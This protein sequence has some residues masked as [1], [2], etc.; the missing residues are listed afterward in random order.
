MQSPTPA[1]TRELLAGIR[2]YG[3]DLEPDPAWDGRIIPPHWLV[4]LP[5]TDADRAARVDIETKQAQIDAALERVPA[6]LASPPD[7]IRQAMYDAK[8]N[9]E[10]I[11][12]LLKFGS[13]EYIGVVAAYEILFRALEAQAPKEGEGQEKAASRE[14]G[15]DLE[16]S[17]SPR[18]ASRLAPEGW[19]ILGNDETLQGGDKYGYWDA[20]NLQLQEV[21][22][23]A[24]DP[25]YRHQNGTQFY[26]I[27]RLE[28]SRTPG[29]ASEPAPSPS[30]PPE[31][32]K[33]DTL[34]AERVSV[35]IEVRSIVNDFHRMDTK[36]WEELHEVNQALW[37]HRADRIL[38]A[39]AVSRSPA[40][41]LDIL[42]TDA[43][44]PGTVAMF[45][46]GK[47]VGMIKNI[48]EGSDKTQE[49]DQA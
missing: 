23:I 37:L 4:M 47:I 3:F 42:P 39:L 33:P 28:A 21:W 30:S 41:T 7:E 5:V 45:S 9:L 36:E 46:D 38:A 19:R 12:E 26:A 31:A 43:V 35:A 48:G 22:G 6:P 40:P 44:P 2:V 10:E 18:D 20:P 49:G 27:R 14:E 29:E 15:E 24:G 25:V 11:R 34:E 16:P 1:P 8:H 17:G 32:P 13:Q